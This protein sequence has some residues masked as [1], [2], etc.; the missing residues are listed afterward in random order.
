[1]RQKSTN[2]ALHP[3]LLASSPRVVVVHAYPWVVS[4]ANRPKYDWEV[5]H[6]SHYQVAAWCKCTSAVAIYNYKCEEF[7]HVNPMIWLFLILNNYFFVTLLSHYPSATCYTT[8]VPNKCQR[9][10]T[11]AA[12]EAGGRPPQ[13]TY[14]RRPHSDGEPSPS[15]PTSTYQKP[16]TMDTLHAPTNQGGPFGT[17]D[18][19]STAMSEQNGSGPANLTAQAGADGSWPLH[20]AKPNPGHQ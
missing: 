2:P 4:K 12:L 14:P 15:V 5:V 13:I 17:G 1:M 3:P 8:L 6:R 9:T 19:H 10:N 20:D 7:D 11:R 18:K 16:T